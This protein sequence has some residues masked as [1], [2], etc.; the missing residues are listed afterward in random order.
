MYYLWWQKQSMYLSTC[1]DFD[2]LKLTFSECKVLFLYKIDC[3]WILDELV[4]GVPLY[5]FIKYLIFCTFYFLKK[6][7][8]KY[9]KNNKIIY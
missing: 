3:V 7:I 2:V 5:G 9:L 4:I 6:Y 1:Q 8:A